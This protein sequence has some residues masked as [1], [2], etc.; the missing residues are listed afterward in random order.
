MAT[1]YE[2][3]VKLGLA[4]S[5]KVLSAV[6]VSVYNCWMNNGN[7]RTVVGRKM[8]VED[9]GETYLVYNY[10]DS[11]TNMMDKVIMNIV[12]NKYK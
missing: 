4:R 6:G 10:P 12:E 7:W 8:Q 3:F 2:R 1:V 11:F 5:N 9:D